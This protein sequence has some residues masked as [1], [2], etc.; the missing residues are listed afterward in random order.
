MQQDHNAQYLTFHLAAEV[1]AIDIR[2]VREIIQYGAMTTVPLMPSFVRGVINLRG[3]VVPVI[4][5]HA[6]FGRPA[7]QVGKKTCVVIFDAMREGERVELGLM[8]DAVSEVVDIAADAIE[9]PPNFGT[10][11][12]RDFIRAM[13]KRGDRFV[14]ILEPDRAFDVDEMANL[15]EASQEALAA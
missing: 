5:L 12:R 2:S 3:S 6:R 9:P 8:V 11:V 10:S 1:F 14:I 15:C 13:G 7:A 4:D